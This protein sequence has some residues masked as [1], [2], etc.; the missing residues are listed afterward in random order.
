MTRPVLALAVLLLAA[1]IALA[2]IAIPPPP[3]PPP[4]QEAS[5]PASAL[6]ALAIV[7]GVI[8]AG[9][10]MSRRPR[11]SLEPQG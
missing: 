4:P 7:V 5:N 2:D 1:P 11:N 6:A 3:P 9:M 8:L 10:W